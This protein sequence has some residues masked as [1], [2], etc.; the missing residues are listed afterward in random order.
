[1]TITAKQI[2]QLSRIYNTMLTIETKG[3]NT[4]VMSDCLRALYQLIQEIQPQKET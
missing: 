4:L 1:M 2:E 3:E